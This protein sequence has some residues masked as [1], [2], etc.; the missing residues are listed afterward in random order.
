MYSIVLRDL[1][2]GVD[3][4]FHTTDCNLVLIHAIVF[5]NDGSFLWYFTALL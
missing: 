1:T 2:K 5:G 4:V 3:M